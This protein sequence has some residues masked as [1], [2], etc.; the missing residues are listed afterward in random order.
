MTYNGIFT[1]LSGAI[2]K[3]G[4]MVDTTALVEYNENLSAL[5]SESLINTVARK[6]FSAE[7]VYDAL[8]SGSKFFL[9]NLSAT[10][11]AIDF[12]SS[13]MG[14]YNS[15]IEAE[16]LLDLRTYEAERMLKLLGDS[17]TINW[18]TTGE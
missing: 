14:A 11:M 9:S 4:E 18:I 2:L 7:G 8:V 6:N 15:R 16:T 17:K 5:W 10:L 12:I 3:M 13:N 1:T